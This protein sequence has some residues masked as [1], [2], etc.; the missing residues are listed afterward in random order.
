MPRHNTQYQSPE[1][2]APGGLVDALDA[3]AEAWKPQYSPLNYA[4]SYAWQ[5]AGTQD[6]GDESFG[7]SVYAY[8]PV[9]F[10]GLLDARSERLYAAQGL[11]SEPD[12]QTSQWPA[13]S[14]IVSSMYSSLN[15]LWAKIAADNRILND[16]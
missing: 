8:V 16:W 2:Y 9:D 1:P 11:V 5:A 7:G 3:L 4:N 10:A 6:L 14:G 13:I 12:P 15:G